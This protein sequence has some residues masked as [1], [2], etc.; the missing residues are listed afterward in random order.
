MFMLPFICLRFPL[1]HTARYEIEIRGLLPCNI[2]LGHDK[3][4]ASTHTVHVHD[5]NVG[6]TLELPTGIAV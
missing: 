3:L 5:P 1:S 4:G 2:A 6:I